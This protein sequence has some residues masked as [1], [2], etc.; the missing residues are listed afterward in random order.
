MEHTYL[1]KGLDY[2]LLNKVNR[3]SDVLMLLGLKSQVRSE[4]FVK[5]QEKEEII[6]LER[7]KEKEKLEREKREADVNEEVTFKTKLG[8]S[9]YTVLT[10][11]TIHS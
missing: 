4:M 3:P 2:A 6:K 11:V 10:V 9:I 7:R 1:V 8:K 5:E